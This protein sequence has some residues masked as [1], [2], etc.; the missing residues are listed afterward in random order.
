MRDDD[1][2]Y[3]VHV[4]GGGGT[5]LLA[6]LAE[7]NCLVLVDEDVTERPGRL[8]RSRCPS[9]RSGPDGA[10][11]GGSGCGVIPAGRRPLGPVATGAGPIT[12]RPLHRRD[13]ADGAN[14]GSPTNR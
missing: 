9:W 4:L 14:C 12:L 11:R 8:P 6:S 3:L 10:V 1:D 2:D 13:G 7:A 5:H